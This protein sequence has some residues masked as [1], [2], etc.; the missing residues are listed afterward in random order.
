MRL[1]RAGVCQTDI[2]PDNLVVDENGLVHVIDAG[3]FI[4]KDKEVSEN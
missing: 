4:F 2:K 1:D 3:S